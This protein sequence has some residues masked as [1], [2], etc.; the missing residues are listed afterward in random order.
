[1]QFI[2][3]PKLL[4]AGRYT[5]CQLSLVEVRN[6][7]DQSFKSCYI[8]I[9]QCFL[10][11]FLI[12]WTLDLMDL[13]STGFRFNGQNPTLF[14]EGSSATSQKSNRQR[15]SGGLAYLVLVLIQVQEKYGLFYKNIKKGWKNVFQHMQLTKEAKKKRVVSC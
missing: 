13:D 10:T 9:H 6:Y 8:S 4:E 12:Q 1:M 5:Y 2:L 7:H 15:V 14:F 11:F 3:I